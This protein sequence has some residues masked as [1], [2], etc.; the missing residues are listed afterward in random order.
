VEKSGEKFGLLLHTIFKKQPE[1]NNPP[2]GKNSPNLVTLQ[3][4]QRWLKSEFH[5]G[6]LKQD[7]VHV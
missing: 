4:P 5:Q 7:F 2:I 3:T 1:V 6:R